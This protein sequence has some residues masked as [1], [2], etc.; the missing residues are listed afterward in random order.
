MDSKIKTRET[1]EQALSEFFEPA[2]EYRNI[3]KQLLFEIFLPPDAKLKNQGLGFIA[4]WSSFL[5]YEY[6]SEI[7]FPDMVFERSQPDDIVSNYSDISVDKNH[8][9]KSEIKVLNESI[10]KLKELL[11]SYGFPAYLQA[12]RGFL[13]SGELE[14]E[15]ETFI[16][17]LKNENMEPS[18]MFS[19][20]KNRLAEIGKMDL[21]YILSIIYVD[22]YKI[23]QYLI[24]KLDSSIP[25]KIPNKSDPKVQEELED[26]A[27]KSYKVFE[28]VRQAILYHKIL[29]DVDIEPH[30]RN[31]SAEAHNLVEIYRK[32]GGEKWSALSFYKSYFQVKNNRKYSLKDYE[33]VKNV[34]QDTYPKDSYISLWERLKRYDKNEFY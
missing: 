11:K 8:F 18:V 30:F 25:D 34:I 23:H 28:S 21:F 1:L 22:L 14:P 13:N 7:F 10:S 33:Y 31:V 29:Q 16:N 3:N 4:L 6:Y 32:P 5:N 12:I 24:E 17:K 19:L 15:N 2:E 20:I 26:D 9:V 27:L